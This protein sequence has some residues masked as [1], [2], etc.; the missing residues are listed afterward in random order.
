V[1][2][3]ILQRLGSHGYSFESVS[4]NSP[5]GERGA[6]VKAANHMP[7]FAAK[8]VAHSFAQSGGKRYSRQFR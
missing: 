5:T 8:N 3:Q 4:G 2:E 1:D 6:T 7:V